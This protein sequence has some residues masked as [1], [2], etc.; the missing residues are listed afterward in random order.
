M[1]QKQS[2]LLGAYTQKDG[3]N[4]DKTIDVITNVSEDLWLA[5]GSPPFDSSLLDGTV[6]ENRNGEFTY[7]K[8]G[9]FN[10]KS[11]TVFTDQQTPKGYPKVYNMQIPDYYPVYLL[12]KFFAA[13]S[14]PVATF[15][16][17]KVRGGRK[18]PIGSTAAPTP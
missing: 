1:A 6:Q 18:V 16:H 3:T 5:M 4:P 12:D 7:A 13:L 8:T 11:V 10:G 14:A 15:T 2:V 9:T 17:I